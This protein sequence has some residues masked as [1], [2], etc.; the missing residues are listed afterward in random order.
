[1]PRLSFRMG[2]A[3]P[4]HDAIAAWV[5]NLSIALGD[6]RIVAKYATREDQPE[7]EQ[8]YFIRIFA[9]HLREISKLLVFEYRDRRDG[10]DFV[11][12]L[13]QRAQDHRAAAEGM[14]EAAFPLRPDVV[15]WKDIKR[16]RDDTFHY[17]SDEASHGRLTTAMEAVA[18]MEGVYKLD[19][20]DWGMRA[21]YADLV[22]INRMHPCE[23]DESLPVT[24]ELHETIIAL[25]GEI[26]PFI[27]AAEASYL[28]DYLPEG[29]V[30][31]E[32]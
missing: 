17:A 19:E 4:A 27:L 31:H 23:E 5:M 20:G 2:D 26:A 32:A 18:D 21:D 9:S 6:L 30:A 16:V 28:F 10:R 22:N 25:N 14:L 15:L 1:M 11:A 7:H 29:T 8:P 13:P 12:I 3:F 24:R